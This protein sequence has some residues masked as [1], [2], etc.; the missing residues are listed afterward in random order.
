MNCDARTPSIFMS[1]AQEKP[2]LPELLSNYFSGE[3]QYMCAI[4]LS[5]QL[6]W[7]SFDRQELLDMR[8]FSVSEAGRLLI[9]SWF[10][11]LCFISRGWQDVEWHQGYHPSLNYH[12]CQAPCGGVGA[13]G[14][15]SI[16]LNGSSTMPTFEFP[17]CAHIFHTMLAVFPYCAH[18]VH[19][20]YSFDRLTLQLMANCGLV[21]PV[22]ITS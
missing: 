14:E 11:E 3:V 22:V 7:V 16:H 1:L 2:A 17:Y 19:A 21:A 15:I 4:A 10:K 9:A 6:L 8:D 20:A 18:I 12:W 5:V 13:P